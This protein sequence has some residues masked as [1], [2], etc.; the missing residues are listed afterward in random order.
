MNPIP[1]W[2]IGR[3]FLIVL[4]WTS[5]LYVIYQLTNR[6]PFFP[7]HLLPLTWLDRAIPFWPWTVV[8]YF[9]LI[10]GM[11][12][13]ALVA[14]RRRFI[15]TLLAITLAVLLNY[16]IF[17]LWPTIYPRPPLPVGDGF[18][19]AWY[20]WLTTIDTPANCFPSGHITTPAIGCRALAQEHP[21]WRWCIRLAF[22]PLAM[23]ILTTKQHYVVDLLGGLATAA[24]GIWLSGRIIKESPAITSVVRH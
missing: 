16:S 9:M 13:P 1:D 18:A 23:T 3:R 14:E 11:Y 15:R 8:P 6:F 20:H 22:I 4:T 17:A 2:R 24:F 10:G 7:A 19:I 5:A 21:R 12:L